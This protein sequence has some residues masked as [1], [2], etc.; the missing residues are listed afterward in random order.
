M[1][2]G[3]GTYLMLD[4]AYWS[5]AILDAARQTGARAIAGY[6]FDH[7]L[8]D[9]GGWCGGWSP[10]VVASIYEAGLDFHPVFVFRDGEVQPDPARCVEVVRQL[11][12]RLGAWVHVD[13][14]GGA[15][16]SVA[17][18]TA[19]N[20]ALRESGYHPAPYGTQTTLNSGYLAYADGAWVA[21]WP[22][23]RWDQTPILTDVPWVGSWDYIGWQYANSQSIAGADV[24]VSICNFPIPSPLVG[25]GG[26]PKEDWMAIRELIVSSG[27]DVD[28]YRDIPGI[29]SDANYSAYAICVRNA[30]GD[31]DLK[32]KAVLVDLNGKP[33][34]VHDF[35]LKAA[36]EE[37]VWLPFGLVGSLVLTLPNKPYAYSLKAADPALHPA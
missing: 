18:A 33:A 8:N 1:S 5:P 6:A 24:D 31:G 9:V 13:V 3:T 30:R 19:V 25:G 17:H 35:N 12:V 16:D 20:K 14:E 36:Q 2:G 29:H 26:D 32:V 4:S 27:H 21:A 11:G 28:D 22:G 37:D 7:Y 15:M 10:Q 34:W 23:L